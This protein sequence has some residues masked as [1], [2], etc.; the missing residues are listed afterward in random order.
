MFYKTLCRMISYIWT[1]IR[2]KYV[3]I[4][5]F[6]L[7]FRGFRTAK[8]KKAQGKFDNEKN[9]KP[10]FILKA[11]ISFSSNETMSVSGLAVLNSTKAFVRYS[12]VD[13]GSNTLIKSG[14]I[15]FQL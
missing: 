8:T 12:L 6:I 10:R 13:N 3:S 4:N 9:L 1:R 7:S 2:S 5:I 15:C 11:D 14:S